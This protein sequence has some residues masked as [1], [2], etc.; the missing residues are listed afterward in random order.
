MFDDLEPAKPAG[1]VLGEDL[2]R[3]SCE[4]LEERLGALDQEKDRVSAELKSKRAGRDAA[5]SIFAR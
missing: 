5:D 1:A 3:L 2:S 4:E